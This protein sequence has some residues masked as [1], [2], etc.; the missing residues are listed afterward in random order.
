MNEGFRGRLA[1]PMG[2]LVSGLSVE[3]LGEEGLLTTQSTLGTGVADA[4]GDFEVLYPPVSLSSITLRVTNRFGRTLVD[5][6]VGASDAN[7]DGVFEMTGFGIALPL[8]F[9]PQQLDGWVVV[10][11]QFVAPRSIDFGRVAPVRNCAV[12]FLVDNH[13]AWGELADAAANASSVRL[14]QLHWETDYLISRFV[15][16]PLDFGFPTGGD[17]LDLDLRMLASNGGEALVIM[18]DFTFAPYPADT[19]ERVVDSFKNDKVQVLGFPMDLRSGALHA[20]TAIVDLT[21][22]FLIASPFLQEYFDASDPQG[23]SHQIDDPRRGEMTFPINALRVPVHDVS[24]RIDG[25]A[26]ADIDDNFRELWETAGGSPLTPAAPTSTEDQGVPVQIVR[27]VPGARL[28]GRP[29]GEARILEAYLRAIEHAQDFIY[30]ENQYV[31][32]PLIADA[33][34]LAMQERPDLQVI[35]VCNFKVDLPTYPGLQLDFINRLL[36]GDG[37]VLGNRIGI[38]TLWTHEFDGTTRRLMRNYV[39]SKT[40]IVDGAWATVGSANLDGV[41]LNRSQFLLPVLP[42]DSDRR[43]RA[44][45]LNAVIYNGV[46]GLAG[47][48][49]PEDLRKRLWAEHLGFTDVEDPAL[50]NRPAEGWQQLWRDLAF[51][52]MA[53]LDGDSSIVQ[54]C[55]VLPW[56]KPAANPD[57]LATTDE[58]KYLTSIGIRQASIAGLVVPEVRSFSFDTGSWIP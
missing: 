35:M 9:T 14:T 5:F 48:S 28:A 30:L 41:S 58:E 6:T 40:A 8:V 22:A 33:I 24:L 19:L 32:E 54:P 45:E 42:T 50:T 38:Y 25:E 2:G 43:K 37:G 26:V 17:K 53:Q 44:I 21:T 39:H 4:A 23:Q 34:A 11:N 1:A 52:K 3:V 10:Q 49:F 12:S 15:P 47:T 29:E 46:D 13:A 7:L 55:R 56:P 16:E 27:T 57:P 20:K 18:N 51:D 31:T 36:A